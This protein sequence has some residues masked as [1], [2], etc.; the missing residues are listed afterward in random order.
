MACLSADELPTDSVDNTV[1][2]GK[3]SSKTL[4]K[5]A[6]VLATLVRDYF[7]STAAF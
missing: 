2:Q 1:E 6:W 5:V 4:S 7:L 3:F